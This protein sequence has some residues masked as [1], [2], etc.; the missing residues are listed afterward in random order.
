M[1]L[2]EAVK[3]K[4]IVSIYDGRPDGSVLIRLDDR[5]EIVI[6]DGIVREFDDTDSII[7]ICDPNGSV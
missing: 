6:F 4:T 2:F 3:G 1:T 5:T 7:G